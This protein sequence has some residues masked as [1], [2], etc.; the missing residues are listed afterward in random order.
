MPCH[1][2]CFVLP[3]L[4][5]YHRWWS[6]SRCMWWNIQWFKT[7]FRE[8]NEGS[9]KLSLQKEKRPESFCW[10]SHVWANIVASLG[11]L[12]RIFI[13]RT[14]TRQFS[15]FF[16]VVELSA[17]PDNLN[18]MKYRIIFKHPI[19]CFITQNLRIVQNSG[20]KP[21][22]RNRIAFQHSLQYET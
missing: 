11:I 21:A 8:R 5:Y 4:Y 13:S 14:K 18:N 16:L 1:S 3:F 10:C 9:S 12:E 17:I 20:T 7:V 19:G 6:I 15:D 22:Y 2:W